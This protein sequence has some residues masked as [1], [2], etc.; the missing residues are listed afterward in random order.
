LIASG[1]FQGIIAVIQYIKQSSLGLKYLGESFL[2]PE[3]YGIAAF[4]IGEELIMRAYGTFPHP[5]VLAA[6][7]FVAIYAFYLIYANWDK[8]NYWLLF[9]YVPMLAGFVLTYSRLMGFLWVVGIVLRLSFIFFKKKLRKGYLKQNIRRLVYLTIITVLVLVVIYITN[10]EA[11]NGR[12]GFSPSEEAYIMRVFYNKKSLESFSLFGYGIGN[13]IE[14]LKS[15]MPGMPAKNYQPVHNI[16]LLILNEVGFFGL[17][18]FVW[19][20]IFLSIQ[21]FKNKSF[22]KIFHYSIYI[23]FASFLIMGF[24][25]HYLWTLQQGRLMFWF[26]LGIMALLTNKAD[27]V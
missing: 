11:I 20:I 7:L 4:K 15:E 2:S 13:H 24:F 27:G 17:A 5:N 21:Y 12:L 8:E 10:I 3:V 23:L 26:L 18:S 9:F 14:W 1:V 25:D 16:Y 19:F 6:F 22:E